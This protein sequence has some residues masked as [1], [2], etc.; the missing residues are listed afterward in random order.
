MYHLH[1][2]RNLRSLLFVVITCA[3]LGA[4]GT[5]WWANRTGL[6]ASWRATI[7]REVAKQGAFI[8]IGSLS[9]IPF[10]GV[11]AKRVRVFADAEHTRE[12]SIWRASFWT[13]KKPSWPAGSST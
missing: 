10:R 11:V 13:S 3:V 7:E 8:K 4:L 12:V 6:P 1:L 9:Y 5:L 2:T